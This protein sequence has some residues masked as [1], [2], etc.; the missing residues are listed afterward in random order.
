[1][2]P[3]TQQQQQAQREERPGLEPSMLD[4][5]PDLAGMAGQLQAMSEGEEGHAS[6]ADVEPDQIAEP[7]QISQQ[8]PSA[9]V[10]H[11]STPS[12]RPA[13]GSTEEGPPAESST[14]AP[15]AVPEAMDISAAAVPEQ[16]TSLLSQALGGQHGTEAGAS[17]YRSCLP[18]SSLKIP[19]NPISG[20][21]VTEHRKHRSAN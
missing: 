7:M 8:P 5:L 11:Q 10:D 3:A 6:A 4:G 20:I 1:M 14:G 12:W 16:E 15:A 9:T 17:L 21:L 13:R 19:L 18:P 2:L